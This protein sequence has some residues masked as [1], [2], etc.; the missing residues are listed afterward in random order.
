MNKEEALSVLNEF[1]S[2]THLELVAT[3]KADVLKIVESIEP[4]HEK[5]VLPH[6]AGK[7]VD[8]CKC[9]GKPSALFAGGSM[10]IDAYNWLFAKD[11]YTNT[12]REE[13]LMKAYFNGW[14]PEREKRY[15]VY[16]P[17]TDQ[18]F[19]YTHALWIDGKIHVE[20]HELEEQ[21]DDPTELF[22]MIEIQNLHLEHCER[23]EV[24]SDD[25]E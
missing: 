2:S 7:W 16:V 11:I 18:V 25:H 14:I 6:V 3:V 22:T 13:L 12:V 17:H 15:R 4:D 8:Q 1:L 9:I 20:A 23:E 19:V 21:S 5:V 10:P 24:E